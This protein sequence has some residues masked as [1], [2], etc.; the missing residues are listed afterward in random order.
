[1][2]VGAGRG[3]GQRLDSLAARWTPNPSPRVLTSRRGRPAETPPSQSPGTPAC[4]QGQPLTPACAREAS[5][6]AQ[7]RTTGASSPWAALPS[8]QGQRSWVG[9]AMTPR[10][11]YAGCRGMSGTPPA[12]SPGQEET[13][14]QV[15]HS[16]PLCPQLPGDDGGARPRPCGSPGGQRAEPA[17]GLP[18][19]GGA[20]RRVHGEFQPQHTPGGPAATPAHPLGLPHCPVPR[21]GLAASDA[22]CGPC[23]APKTQLHLPAVRDL[24]GH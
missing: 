16:R 12:A 11:R 2:V 8:Q 4:V 24:A 14:R 18:V 17:L 1:M 23:P 10:G 22:Y 7:P 5:L 20:Q 15:S 6:Q 21:G 3:L 13:R 9:R 19:P